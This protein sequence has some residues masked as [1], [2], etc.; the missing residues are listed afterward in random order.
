MQ[1]A[2]EKLETLELERQSHQ[3]SYVE[4]RRHYKDH[5]SGAQ[6]FKD[7]RMKIRDE[8]KLIK[9]SLSKDHDS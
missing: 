5:L 1:S 2:T 8:E 7:Q 3:D 4:H 9:K 6:Q